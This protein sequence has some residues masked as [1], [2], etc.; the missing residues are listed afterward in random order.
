MPA[1]HPSKSVSQPRQNA[2]ILQEKVQ[3]VVYN[4]VKRPDILWYIFGEKRENE[5]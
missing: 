2:L 4:V 3:E 5:R 1:F